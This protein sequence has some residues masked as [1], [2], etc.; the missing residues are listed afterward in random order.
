MKNI[1]KKIIVFLFVVAMMFV[2]VSCLGQEDNRGEQEVISIEGLEAYSIYLLAVEAFNNADSFSGTST[3]SVNM[4]MG[5]HSLEEKTTSTIALVFHSPTDLDMRYER[6]PSIARVP[7][8]LYYRSGIIYWDT[9]GEGVG[10]RLSVEDAL[11]LTDGISLLEFDET[12]IIS[13]SVQETANEIE[14]L[15][16][17]NPDVIDYVDSAIRMTLEDMGLD[18][19]TDLA[20]IGVEIKV[21]DIKFVVILNANGSIQSTEMLMSVTLTESGAAMVMEHNRRN[22]FY[23]IGGVTIDFPSYLDN[24]TVH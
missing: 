8:V 17:L 18:S 9:G 21:D 22:T 2:F 10:M 13:Q 24:F 20:T 14:L 19:N 12:A 1:A 23:Q 15:F 6:V 3:A 4:Q 7:M 5:I 16:S 11:D